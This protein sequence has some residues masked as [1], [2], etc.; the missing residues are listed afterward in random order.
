MLASASMSAVPA[1][2]SSEAEL[3]RLYEF[4]EGGYRRPTVA[5]RLRR[6][7]GRRLLR[8]LGVGGAQVDAPERGAAPDPLTAVHMRDAPTFFVPTAWCRNVSLFG[9]GPGAFDAWEATARQVA[10]RPD[11][12]AQE[13]VLA[14]FFER[15]V[16]RTAA[17]R[18]FSSPERDVSRVSPLHEIA[19]ADTPF[20][21]PWSLAVPRWPASAP[22]DL[23]LRSHGPVG[24]RLLELEVW[25]LKRLVA[26]VRE[27]GF[28]PPRNDGVRG[29]L[30]LANGRTLFLIRSGFHRVA[31]LAALGHEE[32]PV[33]FAAGM[34]RLLTL[35]Q[36]PTWPLVRQGLFAP[37]EAEL[38]VE[39]LFT[40]NGGEMAA[41]LGLVAHDASGPAP[42]PGPLAASPRG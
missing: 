6:G 24:P 11:L 33:R 13:T 10:E 19:A 4:V 17:E 18:L 20:F 36:L 2:G 35:D 22:E 42:A 38:V 9:F 26:S 40:E 27:H 25:R 7:V 1:V 39:R 32:V 14:R 23:R 30:L 16:P 34:Q 41:R 3:A 29:Q 15:F 5:A 12:P 31:V 8:L 37:R 21:W 28:R